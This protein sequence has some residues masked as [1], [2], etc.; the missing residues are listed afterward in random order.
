MGNFSHPNCFVFHAPLD[1]L[2]N[3]LKLQWMHSFIQC[4]VGIK[5]DDTFCACRKALVK[6]TIYVV[7][8]LLRS[9]TSN[10]L[11]FFM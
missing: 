11:A 8:W 3:H 1:T 2:K 4:R 9:L 5:L 6:A 10:Y 7:P